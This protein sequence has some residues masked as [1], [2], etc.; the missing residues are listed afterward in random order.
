MSAEAR[1]PIVS[2]KF[3]KYVIVG[4]FSYFAAFAQMYLYTLIL[5]ISDGP[6][7]ALSLV[8]IMCLNFFLARHWIFDAGGENAVAQGGRFVVVAIFCRAAD[9]CLFMVFSQAIGLPY[10][11]AI[12]LAMLLI[13]PLKYFTYK[14]GVFRAVQD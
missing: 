10:Y 1:D 4:G 11:V 5:E 14:I 6:A 2:G 9:W 7:Y 13:F 8:I 3:M 12:F